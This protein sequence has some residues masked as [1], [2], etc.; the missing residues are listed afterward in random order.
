MAKHRYTCD[1]DVIRDFYVYVHKDKA[2]TIPFYVGKGRR[3]R[4]WSKHRSAEWQEIVASL[5]DGYAVEI[6]EENL[7]EREAHDLEVDLIYKHRRIDEGGTL[8]NKTPG[9]V[10]LAAV[11]M[12]PIEIK[13]P[14]PKVYREIT[15]EEK[16]T[17]A[18]EILDQMSISK[19]DYK[20]KFNRAMASADGDCESELSETLAET[21]DKLCETA[22]HVL[23]TKETYGFLCESLDEC[24]S[25]LTDYLEGA[26]NDEESS[27][28]FALAEEVVA[29]LKCKV[30]FVKL[31]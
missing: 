9:G 5:T 26:E 15:T 21:I 27:E 6:V 4:A 23:E 2:S 20:E 1:N 17:L 14:E 10:G 22:S 18:R 24:D 16:H 29:L 28:I 19:V 12:F 30:E 11:M 31:A 13:S 3:R 8:V 25:T 7:T